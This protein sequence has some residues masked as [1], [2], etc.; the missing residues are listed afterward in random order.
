[1]NNII[2]RVDGNQNIGLGH[3]YRMIALGEI[4]TSNNDILFAVLSPTMQVRELIESHNFNLVDISKFYS[5]SD[6]FKQIK[7]TI[8]PECIILDGYHFDREYQKDLKELD[9]ILISIDGIYSTHFYSDVIIN[10]NFHADPNKYLKE[11]YTQLYLGSDYCF[12]RNAFL[13]AAKKR[14]IREEDPKDLTI[15][16]GGSDQLN[17]TLETLSKLEKSNQIGRFKNINVICGTSY[18]YFDSLYSFKEEHKSIEVNIFKNLNDQELINIFLK[19]ALAI[20]PGGY[21]LYEIFSVGIPVV[22][23]YYIDNQMLNAEFVERK[24]LGISVGNFKEMTQ[25]RLDTTLEQVLNKK[26]LFKANQSKIIDG[27]QK[28]RIIKIISNICN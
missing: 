28:E 20:V 2:I 1:L 16:F 18:Q 11:D 13:E 23:G 27:K 26:D 15:M 24:N 9:Y 17:L 22:T 8:K 19:T 5:D 10:Y 3:I 6:F 21:S 7:D 25:K 12:L 4:L 14:Y